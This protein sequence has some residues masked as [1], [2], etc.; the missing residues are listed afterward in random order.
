M[1]WS[2]IFLWRRAAFVLVSIFLYIRL[3][4]WVPYISPF[5]QCKIILPICVIEGTCGLLI[6]RHCNKIISSY[7]SMFQK[8]LQIF[9]CLSKYFYSHKDILFALLF[10]LVCLFHCFFIDSTLSFSDINEKLKT[11]RERRLEKSLSPPSKM[12]KVLIFSFSYFLFFS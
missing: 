12:Q 3:F 10:F 4:M 5:R 6:S 1:P 7:S 2:L 11:I 8:V 9:R